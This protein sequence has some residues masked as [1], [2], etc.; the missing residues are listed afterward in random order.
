M[1]K[2]GERDTRGEII[3]LASELTQTRSF[4]WLSYQDLSNKLEI[5]KA[6]IHYHFPT[7]TDLGVEL[8]RG[9][10]KGFSEWV[11]K[12][13]SRKATSTA[14]LEAY[15]EFFKKIM[16]DSDRVCPGGIF[17]LEW[18]TLPEEM[19]RE[20][21]GL[22]T[23]HRSFL[24]AMIKAGRSSG[25]FREQG[26]V[27]DQIALVGASLQGALQT[28]RVYNSTTV[29]QAVSRQLKAAILN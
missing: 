24:S 1:P 2:S 8:I 3:S 25:E 29:F 7:K 11:E 28:A 26:S 23:D 9:Y 13:L 5:R 27:E 6:S 12:I 19:R 16:G 15:I 22:F 20:V 4:N 10:R 17:S 14:Q 18:N 21:K